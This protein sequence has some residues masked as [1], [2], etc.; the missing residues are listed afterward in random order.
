MNRL[1][2]MQALLG[3][4]WSVLLVVG[5][6]LAPA[7]PGA[8]A[9]A[10]VATAAGWLAI[11]MIGAPPAGAQPQAGF[12]ERSA[13]LSDEVLS[14]V[15]GL[16]TDCT[17]QFKSHIAGM[18]E[19]VGR[20]QKVL[21]DAVHQLS[22]SFHGMHET[23]SNQQ[24]VALDASG[25][26]VANG[27]AG[28]GVQ[29]NDF[30]EDTSSVMQRVVDSIINNSQL[31][32]ELVEL[33]EGIS[34]HASDVEGILG[35]IGGIAKQTNLL[36]LNAAIEAARAG[37]A[38]RGFAVVADEVRDLSSRTG[39]FSQQIAKVMQSMRN[40]V[41][42][43]E[44]AIAKMASQDMTFALNSKQQVAGILVSIDDLNR[45]REE[46]MQELKGSAEAMEL[47]VGRAVTALQFQDMV[48][49]LLNHVVSRMDGMSRA[50]DSFAMFAATARNSRSP[51]E[52]EQ[53]RMRVQQEMSA[54]AAASAR[55]P[56]LQPKV[57][58]GDVDLF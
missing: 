7:F 46:A 30:V 58:S 42:L 15:D 19:E 8:V 51:S 38:G 27:G 32:M 11:G 33:T 26:G 41:Q 52:V 25:K 56:V 48:S 45:R 49:Q 12:Q 37:E 36:A 43:T 3:V 18:R 29:F 44:K 23:T 47:Q 14:Q 21:A 6:S 40:S 5:L 34:R 17:G 53:L 9:V 55:N 31:G 39:Q 35:E 54:L 24:R 2:G 20:V 10:V 22:D 13:T 1:T 4:G 57:S 28:K 50:L 16:T